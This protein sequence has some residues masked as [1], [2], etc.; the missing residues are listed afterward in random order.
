[1]KVHI[2]DVLTLEHAMHVIEEAPKRKAD[3]AKFDER[4]CMKREELKKAE[5]RKLNLYED[6]KGGILSKKE[7]LQLKAEYDRRIAEAEE[8]VRTYQKEVKLILE[9]KSSM[10]H[11]GSVI[12]RNTGISGHWIVMQWLR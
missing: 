8:A 11:S 2:E 7:Y 9:N 10:H 3:I 1:M 6:L 5:G 12:L 4:I